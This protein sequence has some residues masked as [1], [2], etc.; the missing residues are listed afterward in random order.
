MGDYA[1]MMIDGILD[2][3]TGEYIGEGGRISQNKTKLRQNRP[4]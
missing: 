3:Y 1:D 4:E 2:E